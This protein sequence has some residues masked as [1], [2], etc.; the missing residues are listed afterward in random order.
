MTIHN[1]NI[2]ALN[3]KIYVPR[4]LRHDVLTWYHHYLCHPGLTRLEKT[5]ASTMC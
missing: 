4:K 1:N 2:L 5:I 3:G